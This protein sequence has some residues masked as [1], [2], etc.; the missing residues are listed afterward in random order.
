MHDGILKYLFPTMIILSCVNFMWA[1]AM[2]AVKSPKSSRLPNTVRQGWKHWEAGGVEGARTN[3]AVEIKPKTG[4][5][6]LQSEQF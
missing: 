5:L 4:R 3:I 2:T 6:F 1:W